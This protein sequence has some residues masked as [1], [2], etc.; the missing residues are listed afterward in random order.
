[1]FRKFFVAAFIFIISQAVLAQKAKPTQTPLPV[2]RPQTL[3]EKFKTKQK[4][5]AAKSGFTRKI[6]TRDEITRF[7]ATSRFAPPAR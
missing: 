5:S 7:A 3:S 2:V 6:S 4:I 1:M